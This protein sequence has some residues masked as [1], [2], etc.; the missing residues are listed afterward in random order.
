ML[1]SHLHID[2]SDE[3]T[4]G[5]KI[6]FEHKFIFKN[7]FFTCLSYLI[8]PGFIIWTLCCEE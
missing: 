5:H 6:N 1:Y 7:L 2:F 8:F 4:E 3:V